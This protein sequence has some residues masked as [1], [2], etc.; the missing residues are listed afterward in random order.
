ML[1]FSV[2]STSSHAVVLIVSVNFQECNELLTIL[3]DGCFCRLKGCTKR[4][5]SVQVEDMVTEEIVCN[6]RY[7][8]PNIL[9]HCDLFGLFD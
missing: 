8:S 5:N 4:D 1:L 9:E 7:A 2:V 3:R 6:E